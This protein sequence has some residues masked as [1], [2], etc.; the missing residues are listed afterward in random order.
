MRRRPVGGRDG[1]LVSHPSRQ[2]I[3][4]IQS[5][6]RHRMLAGGN[7]GAYGGRLSQFAAAALVVWRRGLGAGV[8]A[9]GLRAPR[10]D[11]RPHLRLQLRQ[12]GARPRSYDRTRGR[13]HRDGRL[14]ARGRELHRHSADSL[15]RPAVHDRF[16]TEGEVLSVPGAHGESRRARRPHRLV[17]NGEEF[18][19]KRMVSRAKRGN[20]TGASSNG[21]E[22]QELALPKNLTFDLHGA[23]RRIRTCTR[24]SSDQRRR[25]RR[26]LA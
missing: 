1:R 2:R 4:A 19:E 25:S 17:R 5:G 13:A 8:P 16:S 26:S 23:Y 6:P 10:G 15:R 24:D 21:E 9:L 20:L 14:Q 18:Q 11:G 3:R 12:L 22:F 7:L